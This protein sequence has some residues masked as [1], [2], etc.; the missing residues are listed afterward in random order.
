MSSE[1]QLSFQQL[2]TTWFSSFKSVCYCPLSKLCP[3]PTPFYI[4]YLE[5]WIDEIASKCLA[6]AC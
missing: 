6:F 1:S 3:P 4:A 2:L 5:K